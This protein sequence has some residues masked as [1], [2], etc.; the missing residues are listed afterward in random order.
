MVRIS[1]IVFYAL[2]GLGLNAPECVGGLG[3]EGPLA[4]RLEWGGPG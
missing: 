4:V 1:Q 2:T 3:L